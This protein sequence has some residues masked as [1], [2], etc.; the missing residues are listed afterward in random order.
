[1]LRFK[2][3]YVGHGSYERIG[4]YDM[5]YKNLLIED[6]KHYGSS[7]FLAT[8]SSAITYQSVQEFAEFFPDCCGQRCLILLQG[9]YLHFILR[10][11]LRVFCAFFVENYRNW[12]NFCCD[13]CW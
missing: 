7:S 1:M 6:K 2:S 9:F 11:I 4:V 3:D 5:M 10:C 12:R 8:L 13:V